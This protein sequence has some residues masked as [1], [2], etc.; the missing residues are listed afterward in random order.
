MT[1]RAITVHVTTSF[2]F[3][4]TVDMEDDEEGLTTEEDAYYTDLVQQA[5]ASFKLDI[6]GPPVVELVVEET[7]KAFDDVGAL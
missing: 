4:T 5:L 7:G 2:A 6:D 1:Q 3:K